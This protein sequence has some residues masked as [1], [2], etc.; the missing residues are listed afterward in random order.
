MLRQRHT[1]TFFALG[2][3]VYLDG[4]APH[5]DCN[6]E[7]ITIG[8]KFLTLKLDG[9]RIVRRIWPSWITRELK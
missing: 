3:R 4:V 8:R 7:L 5:G 1:V 6:G 9:G 2:A